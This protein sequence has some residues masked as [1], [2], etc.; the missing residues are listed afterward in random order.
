MTNNEYY[1]MLKKRRSYHKF[2]EMTGNITESELSEIRAFLE[3]AVPLDDKIEVKTELVEKERTTLKVGEYAILFYSQKTE[4][5]LENIGYIGEQV[6]LFLE[7][8]GIGSCWYGMAKPE[9]AEK[10]GL[11]FAILIAIGKVPTESLRQSDEEF[12]RKEL[13]DI[14]R[15]EKYAEIGDVAR[16]APSAVNSQPWL[17]V[18][19]DDTLSIIRKRESVGLI[20]VEKI[21]YFNKVD[22]GIFMFFLDTVLTNFEKDFERELIFE[23]LSEKEVLTAKYVIKNTD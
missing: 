23:S 2:E 8:K 7:S 16:F 18:E 20:P 21:E 4:G 11:S 3:N 19:K 13:K 1:L 15:G 6:D 9:I 5:W 10:E 12:N 14:W 22:L 17:V